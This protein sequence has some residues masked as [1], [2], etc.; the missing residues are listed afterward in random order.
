MSPGVIL[1]Y[2]AVEEQE[3]IDQ[4]DK[5]TTWLLVGLVTVPFTFT[6]ALA[7]CAVRLYRKTLHLKKTNKHVRCYLLND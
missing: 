2:F 1:Y 5:H 6:A 7:F 4:H 3:D